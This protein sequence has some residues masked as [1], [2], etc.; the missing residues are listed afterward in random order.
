MKYSCSYY[1]EEDDAAI[2]QMVL[3]SYQWE[4]P[5]WGVSRHEF[6]KGLHPSH[7]G[8]RHAWEHTV[9]V[10]R[11]DG[12]IAACVIN[13]GNYDGEAFFLFE[14]QERGQDVELLR[15]MIRFAKTHGAGIRENRRTRFV[16]IPIA[17]WNTV[18]ADLLLEAGFRQEVETDAQ[19]ILPFGKAPFQVSLPEGY[20]FSDGNATPSF[21][22]SNVHRHAFAY[23][24]ESH[25]CDH[26]ADAFRE[27]RTMRHYREELELCVLDPRKLPVAMAIIWHDKA[28]PYCELEPLAV[29]WWER[30]KGIGRAILHELANRVMGKFSD[31]TGML[32]GDQDFYTRIGYEKKSET[33]RYHWELDVVISW[34]KESFDKD[35][36]KEVVSP[37]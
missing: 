19:L 37:E 10:F 24:R 29:V 21:Y 15:E 2:E 34:E 3:A 26:G 31:C 12:R 36:A 32:G 7:T 9:G 17:R 27:L 1:R 16:N 14:S 25:A 28:M 8:F 20:T 22:L 30:R 5:I 4:N 11:E 18:L 13:E 6:C 35:Y 23:G 33:I